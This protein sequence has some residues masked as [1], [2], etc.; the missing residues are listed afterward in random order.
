VGRICE[1]RDW[2]AAHP[3]APIEQLVG[4]VSGA[5]GA[6][7]DALRRVLSLAAG[8]RCVGITIPHGLRV[9]PASYAQLLPLP[10]LFAEHV[11]SAMLLWHGQPTAL[12]IDIDRLRERALAVSARD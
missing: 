8:E 7:V 4:V 12:V 6:D 11:F 3:V 2:P 9:L 10:E 5:E 1:R